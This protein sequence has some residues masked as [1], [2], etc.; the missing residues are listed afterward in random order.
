[1]RGL[2]LGAR[3]TAFTN[4]LDL[5]APYLE[6][7]FSI[8]EGQRLEASLFPELFAA[9][10]SMHRGQHEPHRAAASFREAARQSAAFGSV[11][12]TSGILL[13]LSDCLLPLSIEEAIDPARQAIALARRRGSKFMLA[14]G[15][16][17]LAQ[18]LILAGD[19]D[20]VDV[21]MTEAEREGVRQMPYCGWPTGLLGF[22]RGEPDKIRQS[23]LELSVLA[24]SQDPQDISNMALADVLLA[25]GEGRHRDLLDVVWGILDGSTP[26]EE[27]SEFFRYAV[28]IAIDTAFDLDDLAD[29]QRLIDW[30]RAI[31]RGHH[32]PLTVAAADLAEARLLSRATDPTAGEAFGHA[33]ESFRSYGSPWH[34]A[35][36]LLRWAEHQRSTGEITSVAATIDEVQAIAQQ[37][38]CLPMLHRVEG[39]TA[40]AVLPLG[41]Q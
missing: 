22:Y 41:T 25:G 6:R 29:A 3:L 28:P 31:P 27:S 14:M 32:F 16:G 23:H 15:T 12:Q 8:A 38:N 33:L 24:G 37:L 7:G 17:N 34:I 4:D 2:C 40:A 10:G 18:A 20:A 35:D 39:F 26:Q 21:V 36:A 11:D 5:A 30:V 1:V 9:E 13:N 19:W